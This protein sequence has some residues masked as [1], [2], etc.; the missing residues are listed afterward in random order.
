[1]LQLKQKNVE[2]TDAQPSWNNEITLE[3]P[4]DAEV[5]STPEALNISADN[6]ELSISIFKGVNLSDYTSWYPGLYRIDSPTL[7]EHKTIVLRQQSGT[8]ERMNTYIVIKEEYPRSLDD[9]GKNITL[10]KIQSTESNTTDPSVI[11][12]IIKSIK[13]KTNE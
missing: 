10:A 1:M 7:S 5:T 3:Y 4:K 6:Y 13:F 8:D 9:D 2:T 12:Q 11:E